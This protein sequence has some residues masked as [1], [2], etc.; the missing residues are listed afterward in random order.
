MN[1]PLRIAQVAPPLER[2]PPY[3]Y[4]G[5]ERVVYELIVELRRRGHHVTLFASGD[6]NVPCQLVPTVP[7]ALRP[8]GFGGDS[9][10]YFLST[11]QEVLRWEGEFDIVHS[12]LEWYSFMLTAASRTPVVS[13]FHGRLDFPYSRQMLADRPHGLVAISHS[14]ASGH[15]EVPWTVIHNGLTL[16]NA[17]FERRRSDDLCFVG[18]VAPEKGI[19]EAIEVAKRAGRKIWIAAKVGTLP[20]E[21]EYHEE[22]FLPA[23]KAAGSAAEFLGEVSPIERDRLFADSYALISPSSWPEPFG[24]VTIEALAC[25][26][27]VIARPAGATPEIVRNGRDGFLADDIQ[28]MVHLL[29]RVKDLDRTA[30]RQSVLERFSAKR[31]VDAYEALYRRSLG[32][33]AIEPDVEERTFATVPL[34]TSGNGHG[35]DDT[36]A[37]HMGHNGLGDLA[38]E[39]TDESE[40]A[41]PGG[42]PAGDEA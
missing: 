16:D 13:T 32:E 40:A 23:L 1:R 20:D 9:G 11:A 34:G 33:V 4:G 35:W 31:M 17:P 7:K 39:E 41:F 22:V 38:S 5:T 18:R 25:G 8:E 19:C 27:P 28:Q 26:T 12:H 24:L 29:D 2:V 10:P 3:A 15:P 6:S 21:R 42:D 36:Y 30:I 37:A 14:Q